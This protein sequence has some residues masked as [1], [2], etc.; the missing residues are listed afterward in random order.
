MNK[1]IKNNKIIY[2]INLFI[3]NI[4]LEQNFKG[5]IFDDYTKNKR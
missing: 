3:K 2:A 5:G 4:S 1:Y